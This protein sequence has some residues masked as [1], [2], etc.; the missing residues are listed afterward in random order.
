MG[1][2]RP[3]LSFNQN[4]HMIL[5]SIPIEKYYTGLTSDWFIADGGYNGKYR[6]EGA[7]NRPR[8]SNCF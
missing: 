5:F 1:W 2:F 4:I 8:T 6:F 7:V 3:S